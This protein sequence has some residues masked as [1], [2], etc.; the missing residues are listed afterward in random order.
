MFAAHSAHRVH[1][2]VTELASMLDGRRAFG[3]VALSSQPAALLIRS[4]P[5]AILRPL[6]QMAI[7]LAAAPF[8]SPDVQI[9]R[10]MADVQAAVAP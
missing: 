6:A 10:F 3:N 7:E 2:P 8:V 4:I 5:L 9:D 1:F